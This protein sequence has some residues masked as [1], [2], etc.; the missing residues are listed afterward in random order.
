MRF[1]W[2]A[3]IDYWTHC[4]RTTKYEKRLAA[5]A[6]AASDE[7]DEADDLNK[8]ALQ[9]SAQIQTALMVTADLWDRNAE[10]WPEFDVQQAKQNW[11]PPAVTGKYRNEAK[12][13]MKKK[14]AKQ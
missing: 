12:Q 5:R 2:H 14:D 10:E 4:P 6:K 3:Y 9:R 8:K 11:A 7:E 1:H 13:R